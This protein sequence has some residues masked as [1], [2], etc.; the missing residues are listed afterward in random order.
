MEPKARILVVDDEEGV[1]DTLTDMLGYRRHRTVCAQDAEEALRLLEQGFFDLVITDLRLPGLS[2]QALLS[3]I[4]KKDANLPVVVIS[5][6]GN[7]KNIVEVVKNGAE[8]YLAKPFSQDDLDVV[9]LKSLEKRRLLL[10]NERLRRKIS[11]SS[12]G[13]GRMLGCSKSIEQVFHLI[14]K[15][16]SSD[17][18]VLITGE[19]G[20]GKDLAARSIHDLSTRRDRPFVQ[21]NAG[22]L[23]AT[24]FEAELFGVRKGAY[25]GA[26]ENREGLFQ[27]ADGGTLFLDEVAEVPMES[28]AKLLRVLESRE[29]KPVGDTRSRKVDVRVLAATN[30]NLQEMVHTGH[31]RRDLFFRLSVLPLSIP[32]LRER[33][34][35]I[36]LLV[37]FFL[38]RFA[39]GGSSK[40]LRPESLKA[41]LTHRWP[42]NVRELK[43]VLERAILFSA[44]PEIGPQDL[45]LSLSNENPFP[46]G[47]FRNAKKQNNE[48]FERQY[49]IRT[50]KD[51]KGNVT[52]AAQAAGMA[53]R[54]FQFLVKKYQIK[55]SEFK[56]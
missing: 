54:N 17:S 13:L 39:K 52:Q 34:E 55:P 16:S 35:D 20:V 10:E 51:F 22:A 29:V 50:L 4:K 37:E 46:W 56:G 15:V 31:F 14:Q 3:A 24:L 21:V 23:P 48:V 12:G 5:A 49:L 44:G 33:Q 41:L 45:F 47:P 30:Q 19:S 27:A 7:A 40:K 38:K 1:R 36:P 25:T 18:N 43:N 26:T 28:Q 9:V 32:P 42:G 53:R 11:T 2:G 6:Y 8:D